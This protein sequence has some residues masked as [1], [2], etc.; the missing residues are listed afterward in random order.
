MKK[1]ICKKRFHRMEKK[2]ATKGSMDNLIANAGK[3]NKLLYLSE[4]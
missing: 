4:P 1:G 2:A 3:T